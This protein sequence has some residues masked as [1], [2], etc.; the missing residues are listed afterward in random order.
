MPKLNNPDDAHPPFGNYVHGF[1]IPAN[2]RI[3]LTSGQL[4]ISK[5]GAIPEGIEA[6]AELCF[7]TIESILREADMTME[8][9]VQLRA[10]VTD[11]Y[12][13]P[14]YMSVRDKRLAGREVAST[15]MIVGGF[16]RADFLVEVEAVAADPS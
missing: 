11:R 16:T 9:I 8:H 15:L 1:E 6:Q 7:D 3:I 2:A 4:G 12:D 5:N 10:Y 14:A 13:F